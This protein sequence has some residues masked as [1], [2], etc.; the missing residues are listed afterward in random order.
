MKK[1]LAALLSLMCISGAIAVPT[2]NAS[3]YVRG[4]A[5]GDGVFTVSDIVMLQRFLH[6]GDAVTCWENVDLCKDN[7][8][9]VFD[10][11]LMKMELIGNKTSPDAVQVFTINEVKNTISGA[12]KYYDPKLYDNITW[13]HEEMTEYYGIDLSDLPSK[14]FIDDNY[15]TEPSAEYPVTIAK[16]GTVAEDAICFNYANEYDSKLKIT[17]SK[18]TTP[19][20]C[21][22]ELDT[23]EKV[24][25]NDV[26]V[27][28]GGVKNSDSYDFLY[29]DFSKNGINYR[30]EAEGMWD[31][32]FFDIITRFVK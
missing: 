26:S 23:K 1:K 30:F 6:G 28:M 11:C 25:I 27:L 19:Y 7:V 29:A 14:V 3:E 31:K 4:D 24:N 13:T 2:A 18:I 15:T 21:I 32:E 10:F 16:D 5:N 17:A 8:L 22:Y 9:D 20:D 12:R